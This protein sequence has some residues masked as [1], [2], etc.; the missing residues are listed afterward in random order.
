MTKEVKDTI[1][2]ILPAIQFGIRVFSKIVKVKTHNCFNFTDFF[3]GTYSYFLS[4]S[5]DRRFKAF[6]NSVSR[7]I[8]KT[9]LKINKDASGGTSKL[10]H[11]N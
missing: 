2:R 11:S 3:C 7:T 1:H 5:Q 9:D 8:L 10:V 6:E 4:L